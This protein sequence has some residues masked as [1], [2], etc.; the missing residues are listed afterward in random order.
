[1]HIGPLSAKEKGLLRD[2]A[3]RIAELALDSCQEKKRQLWR[4][5]NSLQRV[6]P[7]VL[8]F[9]EDG[10]REILPYGSMTIE[11]P[12]WRDYEW[13]LKY[14]LVRGERIK[15]DN[16][17][18][19][20]I[21]VPMV[22]SFG[23]WGFAAK[24]AESDQYMGANRLE[25]ALADPA[26]AEKLVS[27]TI[28]IDEETAQQNAQALADLLGDILAVR[29]NRSIDRF[30]RYMNKSLVEEVMLMR[31]IEQV[32]LDMIERPAWLH[33]VLA[34]MRDSTLQL[35]DHVEASYRMSLNNGNDHVGSG[36]LGFTAELPSSEWDGVQGGFRD[37]WGFTDS[38]ELHLVS[39]AMFDEFAI[40]YQIP[41]MARYGLV[42]YGCCE[43]L[44]GKY[45]VLKKIPKLRRISISPWA[46]VNEA[47]EALEDRYV[48]SWKPH[49]AYLATDQFALA[50]LE[51]SIRATL[52]ATR[53][54]VV[55][56]VFKDTQTFRGQPRRLSQAV[57][58]ASRAAE[59]GYV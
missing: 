38:Q 2:L 44:D 42:C 18:D 14:R 58:L 9:P 59:E 55:E 13:Y 54:C 33:G 30:D 24:W 28:Q 12:F 17:V 34:F 4:Q 31:G 16:V 57:A 23:G 6:R 19:A 50:E 8:A 47:A 48:Y 39:P 3:R 52:A 22:Y 53:G 21:E 20:V 40:Q 5:H 43:A 46:N 56:I 27:Q 49:P 37:L 36:G 45:D 26:D 7:M 29:V 41:L 35:M 10:W 25:T 32:W 1:M 51:K 11:D 15:D